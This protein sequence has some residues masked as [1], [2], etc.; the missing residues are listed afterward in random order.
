MIENGRV[1][2]LGATYVDAK[3]RSSKLHLPSQR[4]QLPAF[5]D[6][7]P[8]ADLYAGGSIPNILTAFI[9]LSSNPNV[10]LLSCVGNDTRGKFYAAHTDSRLGEPQ[11]STRNPTGNNACFIIRQT[12]QRLE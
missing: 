4:S 2:G 3:I 11:V 6:A 1:I 8:E 12:L 9:R 7:H 10:K 5:L